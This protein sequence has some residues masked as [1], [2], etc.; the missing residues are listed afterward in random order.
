MNFTSYR[1][2]GSNLLSKLLGIKYRLLVTWDRGFRNVI[3][4]FNSTD[5]IPFIYNDFNK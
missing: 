2:F 1:G 5:G 4:N 3:C